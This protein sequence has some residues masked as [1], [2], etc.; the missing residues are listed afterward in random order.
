M[1]TY[2]DGGEGVPVWQRPNSARLGPECVGERDFIA[3]LRNK[4]DSIIRAVRASV[5]AVK[6][7]AAQ[8]ECHPEWV[9]VVSFSFQLCW[10]RFSFFVVSSLFFSI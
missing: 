2:E 4:R 10:G 1:I 9:S 3:R 5:V 6:V 8:C 7:W